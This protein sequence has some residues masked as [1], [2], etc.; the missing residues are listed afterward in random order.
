VMASPDARKDDLGSKQMICFIVLLVTRSAIN[1]F[2]AAAGIKNES[3]QEKKFSERME[4]ISQIL[5]S[6][7]MEKTTRSMPFGFQD[8]KWGK[9][10][11]RPLPCLK[12]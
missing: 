1:A 7:I 3:D 2:A 12:S 5:S 8:T 10:N 6:Q 4:E 9:K 11:L